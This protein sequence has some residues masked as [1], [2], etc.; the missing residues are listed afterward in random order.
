M[1]GVQLVYSVC[2]WVRSDVFS[3]WW[4]GSQALFERIWQQ[5]D[6]V[7]VLS[8][9]VYELKDDRCHLLLRFLGLKNL[10]PS[11]FCLKHPMAKASY[12]QSY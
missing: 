2:I 9:C 4:V 8:V 1:S 5:C 11:T 6:A 7:G 10:L 3:G 12:G